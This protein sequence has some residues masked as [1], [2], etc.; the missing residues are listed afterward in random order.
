M[1]FAASLNFF[2]LLQLSDSRYFALVTY[3]YDGRRSR[4]VSKLPNGY[5]AAAHLGKLA[6]NLYLILPH[7]YI[8][9]TTAGET[10]CSTQFLQYGDSSA[11][12]MKSSHSPSPSLEPV[13]GP[14]DGV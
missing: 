7:V 2:I 8:K 4:K 1:P 6:C 11:R 3:G 10:I 12:R 14:D 13:L 5:G 9:A